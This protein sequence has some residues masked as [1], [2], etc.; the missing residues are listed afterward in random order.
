MQ[1]ISLHLLGLYFDHPFSSFLS[2]DEI[3]S[4]E[5]FL[6]SRR[7]FP[8]ARPISGNLEGPNIIKAMINIRIN[9]GIPIF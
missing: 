6:N 2:S 7:V 5:E 3:K 9:P 8:N 4:L 1:A